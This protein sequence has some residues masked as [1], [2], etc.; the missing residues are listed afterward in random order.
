M[1]LKGLSRS[2]SVGFFLAMATIISASSYEPA[3]PDR[4]WI[5]VRDLTMLALER[6]SLAN[7]LA[8]YVTNKL[9]L[10]EREDRHLWARRLLG[11]ALTLHP[12]NPR[13]RRTDRALAGGTALPK[14]ASEHPPG[15]LA[16]L[17]YHR[18]KQLS[19]GREPDRA[20]APY[21]MAVAVLIKPSLEEVD[22]EQEKRPGRD[23]AL[24]WARVS[25]E[26][27]RKTDK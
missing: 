24:N 17:L 11:L 19:Q 18:A 1:S 10:E 23:G 14:V 16:Q 2:L 8:A 6:E 12:Q 13:A 3:Q 9:V 22:H 25:G 4:Q 27:R 20:M 26:G 21:F 15:V 7:E 5:E